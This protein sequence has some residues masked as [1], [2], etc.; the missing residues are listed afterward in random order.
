MPVTVSVFELLSFALHF[1]H[2]F[3]QLQVYGLTLGSTNM[4]QSASEV[5]V[6]FHKKL[7]T[8]FIIKRSRIPLPHRYFKTTV[9]SFY[10]IQSLVDNQ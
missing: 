3:L 4:G 10:S 5:N 2:L 7:A 1:L 6:W 8:P 9:G